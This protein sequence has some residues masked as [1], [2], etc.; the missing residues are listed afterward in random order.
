MST[1]EH[2][3]LLIFRRSDGEATVE[4]LG[5]DLAAAMATYRAREHEFAGD[6]DVEVALVGS[7]SSE[8]LRRTHSSFF[9]AS[10]ALGPVLASTR[11]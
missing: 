2:L 6:D 4:E 10:G 8:S 11:G 9:G 7:S 3:F 5:A 1:Q